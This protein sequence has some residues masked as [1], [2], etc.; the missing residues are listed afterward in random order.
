[1]TVR[2]SHLGNTN[3]KQTDYVMDE[4]AA[5]SSP[6]TQINSQPAM[7]FNGS[8]NNNN[9]NN[10]SPSKDLNYNHKVNQS[11]RPLSSNS[12]H[13]QQQQDQQQQTQMM[14]SSSPPQRQQGLTSPTKTS[15]DNKK[16]LSEQQTNHQQKSIVLLKDKSDER[17]KESVHDD[18]VVHNVDKDYDKRLMEVSANQIF[19]QNSLNWVSSTAQMTFV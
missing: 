12:M 6:P 8:S 15:T 2:G 9:L 19:Y 14:L 17:F 11:T 4:M 5:S 3:H 18:I 7:K 1:M 13:L 10:N 16:D